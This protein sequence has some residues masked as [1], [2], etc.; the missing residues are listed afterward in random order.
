MKLIDMPLKSG[1]PAVGEIRIKHEAIGVNYID[2]YHRSGVYPVKLPCVLGLEG[3]GIITAIGSD[4][5]DFKLG[6]R[7]GYASGPLGSYSQERD[8]RGDGAFKIPD[9]I[10]SYK[11][12]GLLLK[13]MTVE[14]LFNRTYKI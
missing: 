8:F 7:V 14:Y 12:A 9:F 11:A 10:V 6:D 3:V 13:G 2:T 5:V 1:G 4:V